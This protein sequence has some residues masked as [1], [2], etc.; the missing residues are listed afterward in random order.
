MVLFSLAQPHGA[1]IAGKAA[2]NRLG[3]WAGHI[4]WLLHP[5]PTS[6]WDYSRCSLQTVSLRKTKH[7]RGQGTPRGNFSGP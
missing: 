5:T 2:S 1:G 7:L 6:R 3:Y 4:G